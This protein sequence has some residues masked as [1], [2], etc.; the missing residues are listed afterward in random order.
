MK[1]AVN[2][3]LLSPPS[4]ANSQSTNSRH[5][6]APKTKTPRSHER[7]A[8]RN[9]TLMVFSMCLLFVMGNVLTIA[10]F[11]FKLPLVY[12]LTASAIYFLS[13]GVYIFVYYNFINKYREIFDGYCKKLLR[14][15]KCN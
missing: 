2:A 8:S 10:S 11:T 12:S 5:S 9:I 15:I 14:V 13:N 6:P 4:E 7:Q 1:G 3:N